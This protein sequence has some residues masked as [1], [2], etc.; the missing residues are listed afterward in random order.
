MA[1]ERG[2]ASQY[3]AWRPK[4][5]SWTKLFGTFLVALD[6]F[7]LLVAAAGILATSLGWW[8]ISLVFYSAWTPPKV[9]DFEARARKDYPAME[10]AERSEVVKREYNRAFDSWALMHELAGPSTRPDPEFARYYQERHPTARNPR[11]AL[12]YGGKYRTMPWAENRGPN[13]F[14]MV[15]TLVSGTGGERREVLGQ[16]A[17]YQVPNL[18]EPLL[19]FLTPVY[20]LFDHRAN[21]WTYL[22][23]LLLI[24]WLLA[25]WAFFGGVITRM[26]VLQLSGKEGG[27]LREA[28]A[29]VRRRYLSYLLS[30]LVPI[31]LIGFLVL[32]CMLFGVLHW[33]PGFGDFWDG[34]FWWLPLLAGLVMTLLLVGM[35]GYP[36]M[37]TTLSTEGSDTFD[38]LSRSYN[39]VYESPWHYLLYSI[40]AVLYGML[41]TLFVVIVGSLA[42]YFAKWGVSKF[43]AWGTDRSPE[44]LFIYAPESLGWRKLLTD[45]S[46]VAINDY[47]EPLDPAAYSR[48]LDDYSWYNHA[49]AAMTSFWVTL[50]FLMVIGFSYSYFWTAATQIY[51]LMR[52][53]VDET[54]TDE[55]YV[56]EE[57]PESPPIDTPPTGQTPAPT[58]TG[59]QSVPVDAPTLRQPE[60][61]S[62]PAATAPPATAPSPSTAPPADTPPG[63]TGGD[64]SKPAL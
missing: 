5:A 19:K 34:L 6:P 57:A 7:K 13:P 53:R 4:P 3:P 29:F 49:G 44:Y 24:L 56:E 30:P 50:V 22:Y 63:G 52:K 27:G 54:E 10:E 59:P 47:G 39:Y 14:R 25:V 12:G 62:G 23:L 37:Y 41:L 64:G 15:R 17:T 42:T 45:G 35:I 40:L 51:L 16:F 20:Y 46:P 38:A 28:V 55:V 8:L 1:E 61:L 58:P 11:L 31:A 2:G 43:P 18:I 48:W 36:M 21:F 60:G 32:C 9:N 26:A 33:V